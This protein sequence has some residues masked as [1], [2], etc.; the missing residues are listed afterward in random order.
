MRRRLA[1]IA[2]WL[3]AV[4]LLLGLLELLGVPAF[5]WISDLFDKVSDVPPW[6]I[7]AGVTLESAQ[8]S[9]AAL[10]WYGILRAAL[11]T[12]AM[13]FRLILASYAVAVALN[14]FLPANLGTF[15][16]LVM[17]TTLIAGATFPLVFSGLIVEKIP[18]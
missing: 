9:L 12:A 7:V 3:G 14:G 1:R 11:P 6:A 8:T 2:L 4:A 18:F 5:D 17:F 10:A 15:V 13:P 16:M